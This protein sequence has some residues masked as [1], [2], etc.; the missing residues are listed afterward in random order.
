MLA[1]SIYP[2]PWSLAAV[3]THCSSQQ[4]KSQICSP[5]LPEPHWLGGKG[6]GLQCIRLR[7]EPTPEQLIF[8]SPEFPFPVK[9]ISK[10]ADSAPFAHA[11]GA[12]G[13]RA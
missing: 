7:F 4:Y 12:I 9:I 10:F 2:W 13:P 3:N 8:F 6:S 5:E 1:F 11:R